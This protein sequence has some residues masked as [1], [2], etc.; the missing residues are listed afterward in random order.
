M[1]YY[2]DGRGVLQSVLE[3][4]SEFGVEV[5]LTSTERDENEKSG[6]AV[7]A[8][9]IRFNRGRIGLDQLVEELTEM[10]GVKRIASRDDGDDSGF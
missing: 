9:G 5:A 2:K 4:A 1:V 10:K 7:V 3:R 8:A 6:T